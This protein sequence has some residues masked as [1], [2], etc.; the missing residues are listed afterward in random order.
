V[1][2]KAV[3]KTLGETLV[4]A[5]VLLLGAWFIAVFPRLSLTLLIVLVGYV[6]VLGL[7]WFGDNRALQRQR[8]GL[9]PRCGYDMRAT[10]YRC[11]ECGFPQAVS[12]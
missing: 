2:V 6:V 4:F 9:C 10:P 3:L 5:P 8:R 7:Q 12:D 1:R 11:P